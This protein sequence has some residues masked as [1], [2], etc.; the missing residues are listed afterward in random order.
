MSYDD[1]LPTDKDK[2]RHLLGDVSNDAATELLTDG[3]ISAVLALYTF[4]PAVAVMATG[5]AARQAQDP[6]SITLPSGLSISG[7]DA[8]TYWL[9]LA[10][11]MRAG[12]VSGGSAF[13]V[14]PARTDGYSE[15][16]SS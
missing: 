4:N 13:S 3:H 1:T 16:A 11:Q 15:L 9:G 8:T 2:A 14:A 5:L 12:G 10:A 6:R 7:I